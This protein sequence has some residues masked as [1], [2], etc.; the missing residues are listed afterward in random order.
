[1]KFFGDFVL[2]EKDIHFEMSL[3]RPTGNALVVLSDRYEVHRAREKLNRKF[4]G[5]RYVDVLIPSLKDIK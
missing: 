3:G 2:R 4:I 1:M 5:S